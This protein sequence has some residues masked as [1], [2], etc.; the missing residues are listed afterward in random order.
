MPSFAVESDDGRVVG[1]G[2]STWLLRFSS[3]DRVIMD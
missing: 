3:L 1:V 2:C